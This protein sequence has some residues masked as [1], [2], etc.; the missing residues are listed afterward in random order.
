MIS[1]ETLPLHVRLILDTLTNNNYEVFLVGGCVRDLLLN[2]TPHDY[3]FTT[4]ATPLE[5]ENIFKNYKLITLGE[6]YGTVGI[7]IDSVIYEITTYRS[8]NNYIDARHPENITFAKTLKEDLSRRDFTINALA[9]NNELIDLFNGLKDLQDKIIRAVGN[10]LERFEEDNL[11]IL[12]AIRFALRFNFTIEPNTYKALMKCL[13]LL[14]N[15]APE[16]VRTELLLILPLL[17]KDNYTLFTPF[18][19]QIIPELE[20]SLNCQQNN[21]HLYNVYD[22]MMYSLFETDDTKLRL[23][24]LLHDIAKPI[25]KQIDTEGNI[26]FYGHPLKSA[27]ISEAILKR[28]KFDNKTIKETFL[29]IQYHDYLLENKVQVKKLLNILGDNLFKKYLQVVIC[30]NKAKKTELIKWKLDTITKMINMYIEIIANKEPY[31]LKQLAIKGDDI[32]KLGYKNE[33]V[34]ELLNDCL[35]YVYIN[36]LLNNKETLIKFIQKK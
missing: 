2:I 26:H 6:K 36:P 5:I 21:L 34:G 23:T 4:N 28:L 17:N 12:R 10:P 1:R 8:E 24:L 29:L 33:L 27:Q 22:H 19:L 15:I 18:L 20:P 9:F 7:L 35:N 25:T 11:R 32:I 16:R 3:D 31:S 14:N 30:D 13:N